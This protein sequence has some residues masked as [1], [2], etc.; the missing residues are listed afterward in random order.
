[1]WDLSAAGSYTYDIAGIGQDDDSELDQ[2]QSKSVN[3]DAILR[4]ADA[5]DQDNLEFLMLV[6]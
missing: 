1:M 3:S 5:T 2:L 6:Q 4:V